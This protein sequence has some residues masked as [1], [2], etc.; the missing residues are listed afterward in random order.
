MLASL[1]QALFRYNTFEA[2][3]WVMFKGLQLL[4]WCFVFKKV[5]LESDANNLDYLLMSNDFGNYCSLSFL[6]YF[7]HLKNLRAHLI[8]LKVYNGNEIECKR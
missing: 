6:N 2:E 7:L 5:I 1:A 4:V 8:G 3:E